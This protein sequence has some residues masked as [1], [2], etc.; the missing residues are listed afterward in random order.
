MIARETEPDRSGPPQT[1]F[2]RLL[3]P[4]QASL[5]R[6]ALQLSRDPVQADDLLQQAIVSG[7]SRIG[8]LSADR[9]FR[10]WMSRIVYRTFLNQQRDAQRRPASEP[11][12]NVISLPSDRPGPE[13]QAEAARIAAQIEAALGGLPPQQARAVWLVDA[14]G[15][16]Y[17]EVAEI[18]EIPRGTA[19]TLV[20]RGRT[21]LR[22]RLQHVA[23]DQ[24]V[25]R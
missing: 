23:V 7:F 22:R 18:M 13:Q 24:G 4:V 3:E 15:F 10:T 9:A 14:Q 6:F 2:E 17:R 11:G 5:R 21:A 25:S 8:Q 19:A 1:R 12:D 20:A 16:K